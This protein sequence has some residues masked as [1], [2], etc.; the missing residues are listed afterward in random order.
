M[1]DDLIKPLVGELAPRLLQAAGIGV[2]IAANCWSSPATIP[3][4]SPAS[5]ASSCRAAP[6]CCQRP[7]A[8]PSGTPQPWR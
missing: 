3:A 4:W 1:L 2:E 7:R 8:R 6:P 5:R